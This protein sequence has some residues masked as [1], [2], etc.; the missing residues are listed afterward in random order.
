MGNRIYKYLVSAAAGLTVLAACEE[1]QPVF[2]GKYP[3]PEPWKIYT[4]ADFDTDGDGSGDF[5]SIS[6]LVSLY[7]DR[8]SGN[9]SIGDGK[10]LKV[11]EDIV[12]RGVVST[13]D[14]PGNFYKS[15]Y[16]Q[17]KTGGIEIKIG[18]NGLYNDYKPGQI[19]YVKCKDLYLGMYGYKSGNYGGYGMVSLGYIKDA[20]DPDKYETSSIEDTYL[21]NTHIFRGGMAEGED[22]VEP[23]IITSKD[24]L[25]GRQ[26]TQGNGSIIGKL[27]T[28]KGLKYANETFTLIYVD[29]NLSHDSDE[30]R[31][32]LS[33][34]LNGPAITWGIRTWALNEERM[35]QHL[36]D[37][38]WDDC[39]V[40]GGGTNLGT[41]AN[42]IFKVQLLKNAM[43]YSVSQYF[44][45]DGMTGGD[46]SVQ[47]R[48]SGFCKF[49]DEKI[50]QDVLEG[51]ATL[52]AT[53]I[54][55]LYQG[56]VQLTLISL[57]SVDPK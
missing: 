38:D 15:L 46:D 2:T 36:K 19:L 27:V 56:K 22:V 1:F 32:F 21:I 33:R 42:P 7:T 8:S 50:N 3:E 34:E 40:G 57:D 12:V 13:T 35:K 16:I 30:N 53:G 28:I 54:L 39:K 14:Q 43:P 49:A 55:S 44:V 23:V 25:P 5:A 41:I 11:T 4:D 17:D 45:L 10:S 6:E 52:D 26:A 48:T 47:I 20:D 37:G 51:K 31:V 24:Q 18:K 9:G 29:P